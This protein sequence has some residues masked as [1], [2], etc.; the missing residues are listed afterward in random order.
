MAFQ[1]AS[2][3]SRYV[4]AAAMS[5]SARE[6]HLNL[7][8]GIS[9]GDRQIWEAGILHAESMRQQDKSLMDI[10]GAKEPQSHDAGYA[11]PAADAESGAR[12]PQE[13]LKMA[14]QVEAKQ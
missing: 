6:Y 4:Q 1:A 5:R 8:Q 7:I 2:L 9:D 14:I 10:I 12:G 11:G 3:S 13:W